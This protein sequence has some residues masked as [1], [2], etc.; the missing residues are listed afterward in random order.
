MPQYMYKQGEHWHGMNTNCAE[1]LNKVVQGL[2]KWQARPEDVV[3][4][5]IHEFQQYQEHEILRAMHSLGSWTVKAEYQNLQ[6]VKVKQRCTFDV[7]LYCVCKQN[8]M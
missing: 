7:W 1:S 5:A 3:V 4:L 6:L 8:E 2:M